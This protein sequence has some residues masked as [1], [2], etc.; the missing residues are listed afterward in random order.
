V[1]EAIHFE[2]QWLEV[3]RRDTGSIALHQNDWD[4]TLHMES[5]NASNRIEG[6]MAEAIH[7]EFNRLEVISGDTGSIIGM[8]GCRRECPNE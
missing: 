3:N 5:Q 7:S 6:N 2:L 4:V 1:A 8:F